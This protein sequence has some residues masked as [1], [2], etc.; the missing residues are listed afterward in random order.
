MSMSLGFCT[1]P[2]L[3]TRSALSGCFVSDWHRPKAQ[4]HR[5]YSRE[6]SRPHADSDAVSKPMR[7]DKGRKMILPF[8][9][10]EASSIHEAC[11][12]IAAAPKKRLRD[13]KLFDFIM[14]DGM[15]HGIY[16][17]FAP[18]STTCLFVGKNSSQQFIER[19]PSHFAISEASWMNHFLK[20]Y[21]IQHQSISLFEAAKDAGDCH[22]LL[23]PVEDDLIAKAEKFFRIFQKPQFNTL[24]KASA[25]RFLSS[26]PLDMNLGEVLRNNLLA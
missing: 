20:R 16:F 24:K 12:A 10:I 26:I 22:I 13:A 7:K 18:D 3:R 21:R 25:R 4:L 2:P 11:S 23:M 8:S 14:Q 6:D 19:I 5:T 9:S 15:E 1:T 17:F